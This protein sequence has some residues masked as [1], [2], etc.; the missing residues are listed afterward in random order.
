MK[1]LKNLILYVRSY[2]DL[3]IR[4]IELRAMKRHKAIKVPLERSFKSGIQDIIDSFYNDKKM[5]D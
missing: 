3:S 1:D 2:E 5:I 4:K